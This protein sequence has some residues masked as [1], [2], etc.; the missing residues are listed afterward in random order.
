MAGTVEGIRDLDWRKAGLAGVSV[1]LN[2]ALIAVLSFTALGIDETATPPSPPLVY[3]D[4]APRTL[5]P[6]EIERR[7]TVQAPAREAVALPSPV[8]D[9]SP[10]A[11]PL[12]E[13]EEDD[14]PAPPRPRISRAAPAGTPAPPAADWTVRP[15]IRGSVARS[16][17]HGLPGCSAPSRLTQIERDACREDFERRASAAPPISGT[18]DPERDAAFA[19]EGARRLAQWEAQRRPLSGGVGI[20]KPADCVGSNFGTGC[21]GAH[22]GPVPGTDMRQGADSLIRQNSNRVD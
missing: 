16:L 7:P 9:A 22:L 14:R 4:I 3:L 2:V 12:D 5:L 8:A 15:D 17:R 13:D 18:G 6:G 19:R 20:T 10:V 11:R 1:V 21:A